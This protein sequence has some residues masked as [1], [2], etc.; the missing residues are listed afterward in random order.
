MGWD[1]V[2]RLGSFV[3]GGLGLVGVDAGA[4]AAMELVT[5]KV[6]RRRRVMGCIAA[7]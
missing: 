1:G 5:K 3:A 4:G 7:N 6:V 2:G